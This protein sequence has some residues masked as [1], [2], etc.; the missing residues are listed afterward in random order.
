MLMINFC[1]SICFLVKLRTA[2]AIRRDIKRLK[3]NWRENLQNVYDRAHFCWKSSV[4]RLEIDIL[5]FLFDQC[6]KHQYLRAQGVTLF[7]S[8]NW[9]SFNGEKL[10]L[11]LLGKFLEHF[12]KKLT[13]ASHSWKGSVTVFNELLTHNASGLPWLVCLKVFTFNKIQVV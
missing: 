9:N 11:I 12:L 2:P 5:S 7:V 6:G 10:L 13:H 3:E 4:A 8:D 1:S